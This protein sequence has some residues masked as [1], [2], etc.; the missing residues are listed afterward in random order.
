[1]I[2]KLVKSIREYKKSTVLTSICMVL[3]VFMEITIPFLSNVEIKNI[4]EYV[5]QALK[6]ITNLI[7]IEDKNSIPI[8][9]MGI[10][11]K[12]LEMLFIKN[13]ERGKGLGKQLLNYGI[14]NYNV[15]ELTV[16]EQNINS[17]GFYEYDLKFTDQRK[18][19]SDE[20]VNFSVCT[21]YFSIK[22][23][24]YNELANNDKVTLEDIRNMPIIIIATKEQRESE[25][26]FYH[27]ILGF[28]E[29]FVFVENLEEANLL[30]ACNKGILPIE[31]RLTQAK[32]D[33]L[34]FYL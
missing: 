16:N 27:N 25:S 14:K 7:I 23:P 26:N 13:S 15:N 4:K 9:F 3:E 34:F 17:R 11:N 8:A 18:A 20:F 1:M 5:P 21:Q 30:V 2:K 22:V 6:G 24:I 28:K 31:N 32:N 10:E 33:L 29:N 19:F 12:R